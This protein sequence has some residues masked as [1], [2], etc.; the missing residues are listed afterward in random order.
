[1][2]L[3]GFTPTKET[4]DKLRYAKLGKRSNSFNH[5]LSLDARKKISLKMKEKNIR[6]PLFS[7]LT[8]EKQFQS[9][10][11]RSVALKGSKCHLWRGGINPLNDSIRKSLEYKLWRNAVFERDNWKCIWCGSSKGINADHIQEFSK[12]PELRFAIDNGRTLCKSCHLL[13][14]NKKYNG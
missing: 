5:K 1:M 11:K 10:E 12:Y 2:P 4:R 9:R 8:P 13:R 7:E 14:H 3:K 6:P